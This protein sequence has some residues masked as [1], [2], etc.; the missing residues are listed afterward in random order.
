MPDKVKH[1]KPANTRKEL[2]LRVRLSALHKGEIRDA[3]AIA[4]ISLSAWVTE[5]LLKCARQ[6]SPQAI[7]TDYIP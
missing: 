7:K 3:A 6:E 4:G 2:H 5:R 1:R